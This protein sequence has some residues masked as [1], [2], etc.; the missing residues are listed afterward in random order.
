MI[1]RRYTRMCARGQSPGDLPKG[2]ADEAEGPKDRFGYF[3]EKRDSLLKSWAGHHG[4]GEGDDVSD[5]L[6]KKM[7][8]V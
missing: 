3:W 6:K 1:Y 5:K 4:Q 8:N 2:K 7:Q